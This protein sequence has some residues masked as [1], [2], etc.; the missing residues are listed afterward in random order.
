[1]AD[2]GQKHVYDFP[3]LLDHLVLDVLGNTGLEEFRLR[4]AAA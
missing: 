4:P 2:G 1:M 3:V